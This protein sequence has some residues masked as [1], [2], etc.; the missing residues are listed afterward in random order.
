MKA[1]VMAGLSTIWLLGAAHAAGMSNQTAGIWHGSCVSACEQ[2]STRAW[3]QAYC[4]CAMERTQSDLT[5]EEHSQFGK[6]MFFGGEIDPAVASKFREI[7]LSC[8]S[9]TSH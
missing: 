3:C 7:I 5:D 9:Q 2:N 6:A 1:L 8:A 4:D